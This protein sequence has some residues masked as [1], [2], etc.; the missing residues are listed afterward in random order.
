M[1]RV[2]D[3]ILAQK[4]VASIE[5]HIAPVSEIFELLRYDELAFAR[6]AISAAPLI[7][8]DRFCH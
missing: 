8:C 2:C 4:G 3:S 1:R 7:Y 6:K 5:S